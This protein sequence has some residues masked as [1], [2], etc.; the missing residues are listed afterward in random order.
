[1]VRCLG[2]TKDGVCKP[3]PS[4]RVLRYLEVIRVAQLLLLFLWELLELPA[5]GELALACWAETPE[6]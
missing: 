2:S 3:R 6:D 4:R 5:A 1:M